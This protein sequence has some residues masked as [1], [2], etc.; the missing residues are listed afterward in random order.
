MTGWAWGR[1]GWEMNTWEEIRG[2]NKSTEVHK[3]CHWNSM[4]ITPEHMQ[5]SYTH[6]V[7]MTEVLN[8]HK[9]ILE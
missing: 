9:V 8:V 4:V 2:N 1:G 6:T 3:S 7:A 5:H